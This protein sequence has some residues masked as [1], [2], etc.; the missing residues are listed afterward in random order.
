MSE[1]YPTLYFVTGEVQKFE[2][3]NDILDTIDLKWS[4]III[5]A[6]QSLL[7]DVIIRDKI[8]VVRPQLPDLPF[9]VEHSGVTIRAWHNMPGGLTSI[10]MKTVGPE[11]ICRM[12]QAYVLPEERDAVAIAVIG[13]SSV[14]GHLE[15]FRSEVP[16]MIAESPRG[17]SS[18]GWDAIFIPDGHNHTYAEMESEELLR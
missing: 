8:S 7:F 6:R 10:F 16:G 17:N 5:D 3:Y 15:F 2:V 1:K 11:G 14:E 12:M 4:E 9:F 13:C 18:F